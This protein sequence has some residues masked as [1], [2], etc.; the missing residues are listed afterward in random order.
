MEE[1]CGPAFLGALETAI[2]YMSE[3]GPIM[4]AVWGGVE[5]WGDRV[6][7]GTRWRVVLQ[8]GCREGREIRKVWTELCAEA[9][10]VAA[11]LGEDVKEVFQVREEGVGCGSVTGETRGK[12]VEAREMTRS[13]LLIRALEEFRPQKARPVWSWRQRDKLSTAWLRALPLPHTA[14]S[15][16]EFSEAAAASLCLPSPAC[17]DRV[18]EVINGRGRKKIDMYGDHIQSTCLK[19]DHWR[20]RHD[21]VKLAIYRLCMW[22]GIPVEME[23]FNLFS[24]L[25]PQ[26]G[27][28]RIERDRQRQSMVPDFRITLPWEG[29]PRPVLH[30]LKVISCSKTGYKPTMEDRAVDRRAGQLH[31]EYQE[32]ARKTDRDF[33][34][35]E[36]GRVG[37]VE[38]KLLSFPTV[39]LSLNVEI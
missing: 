3:I 5:C 14:L 12:I 18:G 6:D 7:T 37:P 19:G 26:Q 20:Q 31:R 2:P 17:Q 27:L 28:A 33:G 38:N 16:E 4:E 15:N 13:K 29:R 23:V 10:E 24:G 25:I 9:V 8:S 34:G 39:L 11:W 22:V 36:V 32:K 30:E 35:V 21:Q 1:T